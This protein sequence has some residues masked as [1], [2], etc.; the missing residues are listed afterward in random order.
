MIFNDILWFSVIC[1]DSF[2]LMLYNEF[3]WSSTIFYESVWFYMISLLSYGLGPL[4]RA[5]GG[6]NCAIAVG[7]VLSQNKQMNSSSAS[8]L[9]MAFELFFRST[10]SKDD[11]IMWTFPSQALQELCLFRDTLRLHN[12]H[13]SHAQS[14]I[15]NCSNLKLLSWNDIALSCRDRCFVYGFFG[16]TTQRHGECHSYSEEILLPISFAMPRTR[17]TCTRFKFK[18]TMTIRQDHANDNGQ[19]RQETHMIPWQCKTTCMPCECC[20]QFEHCCNV[21]DFAK[22]VYF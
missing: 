3:V 12:H 19:K 2:Y 4:P 6:L 18:S 9:W 7:N 21:L 13:L 14:N 11:G 5:L 15:N 10:S 1:N 22:Y 16:S 20:S 8:L 17:G